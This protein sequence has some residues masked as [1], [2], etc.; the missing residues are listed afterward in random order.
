MQGVSQRGSPTL[1][2]LLYY[3]GGLTFRWSPVLD[4]GEVPVVPVGGARSFGLTVAVKLITI[5]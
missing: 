3:K 2:S 1:T 5:E 4:L